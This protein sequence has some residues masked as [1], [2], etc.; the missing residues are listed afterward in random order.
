MSFAKYLEDDKSIFSGRMFYQNN[1]TK[2]EEVK[3]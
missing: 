1:K 2:K 3:K